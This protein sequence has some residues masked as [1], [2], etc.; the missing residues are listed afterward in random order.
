[1]NLRLVTLVLL[2]ACAPAY[3][4]ELDDARRHVKARQYPQALLLYDAL[5]QTRPN[6]SDLLIETARVSGWDDRH[7][8][9]IQL[10]RRVIEIAPQRIADVRL[11]LA[12]QLL[13]AGQHS[14]ARTLFDAELQMHPNS[15]DALHG[16]A[17]SA[18]AMNHLDEALSA[19]WRLLELDSNDIQAARGEARVLQWM[20]KNREAARAYERIL[21]GHPD[22]REAKLRLARSYNALG[23][24][25]R[26]AR[27]IAPE[28][29]A[30]SALDDRLEYARALRWS[31]LDDRALGAT[32]G[33]ESEGAH[34]LR[35]QLRYDLADRVSLSAQHSRDSDELQINSATLSTQINM[36]AGQDFGLSIRRIALRQNGNGI[37][38]NHY[39][40]GYGLRLG[41]YDSGYGILWPR[42]EIGE[43]RFPGWQTTAWKARA[44]WLPADLWRIDL[45]A[46]NEI[47]ENIQS[48]NNRVRLDYAS[49]G[50]DYR[51]APRWLGSVALLTGQFDDGNRRRRAAGRIEY[52]ALPDPR[53]TLG[54]E[55]MGFNDSAPPTPGRG[56]YSPESYRE[57][58]L[59]A[60][61]E[62]RHSGWDL[63]LKGAFG[64]I[65]ETG[66]AGNMLYTVEASASRAFSGQGFLRFNLGRSDSAAV[67]SNTRGGYVRNYFGGTLEFRF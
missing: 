53:L 52:L 23:R 17:E 35:K 26:A 21:A 65:E 2:L 47:I 22:D 63:Y 19:Y 27:I 33:L 28:I 36:D 7:D 31:G 18:S 25:Q 64:R 67:F 41:S 56:Y 11:A 49:A 45:E 3:A 1:M 40:L 15:R 60:A 20:G 37:D 5:L 44:K 57:V 4:D 66:S 34:A 42:V 54:I 58:K 48:I 43:R 12:W 46:G 62:T 9:A 39:M 55:A 16:L 8:R 10:Y 6:D 13:W 30:D 50:L 38:G 51:F 29:S 61:I 32:E 59:A 24:H 14:E